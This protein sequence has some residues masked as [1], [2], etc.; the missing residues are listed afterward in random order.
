MIT[1]YPSRVLLVNQDSTVRDQWAQC[2]QTLSTTWF[3]ADSISEARD[4]LVANQPD[5]I[6]YGAGDAGDALDSWM[7]EIQSCQCNQLIV[8][9][10]DSPAFDFGKLKTGMDT[11]DA[12]L[13]NALLMIRANH[14]LYQKAFQDLTSQSIAGFLDPL[15]GLYNRILFHD[16]GEKELNRCQRYTRPMALIIIKVDDLKS[17]NSNFGHKAGDSLITQLA[18]VLKQVTRQSDVLARIGNKEFGIIL[19]EC[20]LAQCN[21]RAEQ[22]IETFAT[23]HPTYQGNKLPFSVSVGSA[24]MDSGDVFLEQLI[25]RTD[26]NIHPSL[27]PLGETLTTQNN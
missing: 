15:T 20:N 10:E 26:E 1:E 19:S 4:S 22:L 17:I 21:I 11:V 8:L 27:V 23:H 12:T 2:L 7:T 18:G 5:L 25:E 9:T 24:E 14:L 16:L 3:H 6:I 13:I